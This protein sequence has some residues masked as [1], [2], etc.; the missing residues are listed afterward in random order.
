MSTGSEYPEL[1]TLAT[2]RFLYLP[3]GFRAFL[4]AAVTLLPV[5]TIPSDDYK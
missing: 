3:I 5:K 2:C 1:S 4:S